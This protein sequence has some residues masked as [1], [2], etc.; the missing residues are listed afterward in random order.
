VSTGSYQDL[1]LWQQSVQL[2]LLINALTARFPREERYELTS[3]LRRASISVSAN[4]AEGWGR[5]SR[6]ELRFRLSISRGSLLEVESDLIIAERLGYTSEP[7]L[8]TARALI[9]EIAKM[10]VGLRRRLVR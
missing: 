10:I 1:T 4:I 3:Q 9:V 5:G 8:S 6:A 7:D 2:A